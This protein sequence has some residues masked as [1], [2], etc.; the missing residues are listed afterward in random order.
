VN[1]GSSNGTRE[2]KEEEKERDNASK[3]PERSR[4]DNCKEKKYAMMRS[5]YMR[6][7]RMRR[8]AIR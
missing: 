4:S 7:R 6:I 2:Q 5:S 3:G 1:T 8:S